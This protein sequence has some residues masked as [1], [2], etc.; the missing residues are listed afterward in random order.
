MQSGAPFFTSDVEG[1]LKVVGIFG[2]MLTVIIGVI[3]KWGQSHE[4]AQLKNLEDVD[5]ALAHDLN[6]LG[7]KVD[8]LNQDCI[9]RTTVQ[10]GFEVRLSRMDVTI[11]QILVV[12]GEFKSGI[13]MLRSQGVELQRDMTSLIMESGRRIETSVQQVAVEVAEL[14]AARQERD[15]LSQS[16]EQFVRGIRDTN[17]P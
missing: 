17:K 1:F 12:Q 6:A 15:R 7:L 3:V 8:T 14:R 4:T 9:K 10:D 13:E 2:G 16:L 11:Q 5:K